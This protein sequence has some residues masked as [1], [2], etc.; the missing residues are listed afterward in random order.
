MFKYLCPIFVKIVS[1][2]VPRRLRRLGGEVGRRPSGAPPIIHQK[3]QAILLGSNSIFLYTPK[4]A[5][6]CRKASFPIMY[7]FGI[8]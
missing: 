3:S 5:Q 6:K 4:S 1:Y 2:M 7:D 8:R